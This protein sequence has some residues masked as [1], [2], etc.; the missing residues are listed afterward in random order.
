MWV[1]AL[2]HVKHQKSLIF[3]EMWNMIYDYWISWEQIFQINKEQLT[4][5]STEFKYSFLA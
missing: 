2:T 4:P 1:S 3:R 5:I